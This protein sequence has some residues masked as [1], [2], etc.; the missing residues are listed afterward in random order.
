MARRVEPDPETWWDRYGHRLDTALLRHRRWGPV[1]AASLTVPPGCGGAIIVMAL[2]ALGPAPLDTQL[3]VTD[4]TS[5]GTKLLHNPL[6]LSDEFG[7]TLYSL[8]DRVVF[9]G[10]EANTGLEPWVS[11]GTEAGTL[12]LQ[13]IHASGSSY[14][15]SFT[16][17]G[18]SKLFFV[19]NDGVHGPELW[20][21]PVER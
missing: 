2:Y 18:S 9:S 17:V 11:D 5:A 12:L 15:S 21:M 7:S 13:N 6:S 14:P 3:W 10:Y 20:M 4:A 16:R 8:G 1:V 19:A